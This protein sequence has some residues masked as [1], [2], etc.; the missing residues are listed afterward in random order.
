MEK[1]RKRNNHWIGKRL[2]A[3]KRKRGEYFYLFLVE[4]DVFLSVRLRGLFPVY[5]EEIR[6]GLKDISK[7]SR[8][9]DE[10]INDL[11]YYFLYCLQPSLRNR[12]QIFSL[13][14]NYDLDDTI[15]EAIIQGNSSFHGSFFYS[16]D[17]S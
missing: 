9:S 8:T 6:Q 14:S 5:E 10:Q 7:G 17:Y 2:S 16:L 4:N 1:R 13:D 12:I 11:F 15:F 3:L